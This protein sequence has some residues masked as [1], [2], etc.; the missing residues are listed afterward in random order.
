MGID[1]TKQ[2]IYKEKG[3]DFFEKFRWINDCIIEGVYLNGKS[4]NKFERRIMDIVR[5]LSY[6]GIN[7]FQT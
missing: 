2:F 4:K 6:I 3:G 5:S 1:D 7:P